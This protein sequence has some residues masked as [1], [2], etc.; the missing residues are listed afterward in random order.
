MPAIFCK[1]T[2]RALGLIY[3]IQCSR[4]NVDRAK[5]LAQWLGYGSGSTLRV[6]RVRGHG[7]GVICVS[8]KGV[9]P[10]AQCDQSR[11]LELKLSDVSIPK[12]RSLDR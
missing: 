3:D 11:R 7:I 4:H 2:R 8:D 1:P 6:L 10:R 9:K 5:C 12:E